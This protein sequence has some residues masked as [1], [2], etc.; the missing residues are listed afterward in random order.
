MDKPRHLKSKT[1]LP[2][3]CLCYCYERSMDVPVALI[4]NIHLFQAKIIQDEE[5]VL[6]QKC[7]GI[8][9][10]KLTPEPDNFLDTNNKKYGWHWIALLAIV[11][12]LLYLV[13]S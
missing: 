8:P 12:C 3:G 11:L 7:Q 2:C 9:K 6:C 4:G 5:I 1:V 10:V 13:R